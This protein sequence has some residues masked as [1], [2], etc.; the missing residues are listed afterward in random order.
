METFRPVRRL[1]V[2]GSILTVDEIRELGVRAGGQ[3][4]RLGDIASVKRG[5][6]DPPS[7]KSAKTARKASCSAR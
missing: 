3:T 2:Q 6:E 5:V 1:D 7:P 4:I